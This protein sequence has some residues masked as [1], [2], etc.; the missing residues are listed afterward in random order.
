MKPE[1]TVVLIR[2]RLEQAETALEDARF[3][4]ERNRST[5]SIINRS[6]YA[7]FYAALALLQY[8]GH[9]PMKHTG[10]LSPL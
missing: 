2:H 5:Q 3:L 1:E 9:V 6:D 10:V 4:L 8:G 7:M